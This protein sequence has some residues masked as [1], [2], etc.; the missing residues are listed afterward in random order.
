MLEIVS[1]RYRAKDLDDKVAIY[2]QAGVMEYVI[3]D[4]VFDEHNIARYTVLGYYLKRGHYV[5]IAPDERGYIYSATNDVWIGVSSERDHFFVIDA[6][7]GEEI[8]PDRFR[9][10]AAEQ[11]AE[12][13]RQRTEEER[14]RADAAEQRQRDMEAELTRLRAELAQKGVNP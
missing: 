13:E 2:E 4:S 5:S 11:R 7:T 9:A 1:P 10:D 8:V 12:E 14:Q 6:Q 3:I